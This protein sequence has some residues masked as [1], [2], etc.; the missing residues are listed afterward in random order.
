MDLLEERKFRNLKEMSQEKNHTFSY[1]Y[2]KIKLKKLYLKEAKSLFLYIIF[3]I[4]I[5][6]LCKLY[7]FLKYQINCK[8]GKVLTQGN[9]V[10]QTN[11]ICDFDQESNKIC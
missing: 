11:F 1:N 6:S 10:S 4:E 2:P 9:F 8:V 7:C 5:A 3:L